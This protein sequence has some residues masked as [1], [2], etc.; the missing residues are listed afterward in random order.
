MGAMKV[1]LNERADTVRQRFESVNTQH[2]PLVDT[3]RTRTTGSG[4]AYH[5]RRVPRGA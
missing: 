3:T 4:P 1:V 2:N 5:R